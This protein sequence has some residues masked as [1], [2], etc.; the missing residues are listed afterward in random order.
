MN[1]QDYYK[2][3]LLSTLA[4]V[5][6]RRRNNLTTAEL[7]EDANNAPRIPGVNGGVIDTL[8]EKIFSP[9]SAGRQGWQVADFQPND[10]AGFA[11]SLFV[12]SDTGEKVLAIRGTEPNLSLNIFGS[13]IVKDLFNADFHE[14]GEYGMAV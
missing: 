8:G 5:D 1:I 12:N 7:I 2:Y 9:T 6:W 3:S 4:Y 14:I 10:A 13:E 11:A